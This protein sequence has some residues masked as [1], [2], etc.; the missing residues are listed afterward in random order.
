MADRRDR[1]QRRQ[2]A[3]ERRRQESLRARRHNLVRTLL[4]FVGGVAAIALVIGG[5]FLFAST[6]K[7]LPPTSFGPGHIEESTAASRGSGRRRR[8]TS[9][10][11]GSLPAA[12][13]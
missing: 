7:N 4:I 11:S 1:Y 8:L 2:Q 9:G 3:G 12:V 10:E 6:Q 5:I 13:N